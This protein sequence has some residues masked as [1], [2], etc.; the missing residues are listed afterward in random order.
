[1]YL[2]LVY[3][4]D[5]FVSLGSELWRALERGDISEVVRLYNVALSEIPYDDY[6]RNRNEY[7]YRSMFVM[8]LRGAGRIVY[9]EVH[10]YQ[11]LSDVVIQ[12]G[13]RIVV[14]ELKFVL[15]SSEVEEKK[16]EGER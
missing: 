12:F 8:L 15:R 10:T 13:K 4:V 16:L 14:L 9:A 7:W 5:N 6:S 1:M 3:R 2:E 11:G